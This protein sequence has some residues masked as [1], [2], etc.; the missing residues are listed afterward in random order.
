MCVCVYIHI[1]KINLCGN[2]DSESQR[3]GDKAD[4]F[5]NIHAYMGHISKVLCIILLYIVGIYYLYL[6]FINM[7][8][9]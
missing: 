8:D 6:Y 1:Q 3:C 5:S 7:L 9:V 4:I 2:G